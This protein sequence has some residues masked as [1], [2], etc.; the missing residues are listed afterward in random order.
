MWKMMSHIISL[1]ISHKQDKTK[2][3]VLEFSVIEVCQCGLG[4]L[5][6]VGGELSV[7]QSYQGAVHL[8][9]EPHD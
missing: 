3:A 1:M 2:I 5:L 8:Y 6:E 7:G 4:L 9:N